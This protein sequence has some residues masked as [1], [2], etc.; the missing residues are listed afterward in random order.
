MNSTAY[1][2]HTPELAALFADMQA[3]GAAL[4]KVARRNQLAAFKSPEY[5]AH[6]AA[7]R[8]Y[9]AAVDADRAASKPTV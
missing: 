4:Q 5:A 9:W 6:K 3:K 8:A 1:P 2:A 7:Y